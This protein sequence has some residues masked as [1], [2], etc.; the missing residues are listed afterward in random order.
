MQSHYLTRR[1]ARAKRSSGS[2][3]LVIGHSAGVRYL[4]LAIALIVVSATA[5]AAEQPDFRLSVSGELADNLAPDTQLR[6][7][8]PTTDTS[9]WATFAIADLPLTL[10]FDQF[11]ERQWH[12]RFESESA[13][14]SFSVVL[15]Q[16][17]FDKPRLIDIKLDAP[18]PSI[19]PIFGF[20]RDVLYTPSITRRMLYHDLPQWDGESQSLTH[21]QPP[22]MVITSLRDGTIIY[23]GELFEG[24]MASGWLAIIDRNTDLRDGETY[25]MAVTYDSGGLFPPITTTRDF[26]YH[27]SLHGK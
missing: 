5:L 22:I 21:S 19:R 12:V 26:T 20:R 3:G 4:L 11:K 24:C 10:P 8:Y 25:R 13:G 18:Q 15:S 23:D 17:L 6:F 9:D 7:W 16:D 27:V 2:G 14:S 1:L